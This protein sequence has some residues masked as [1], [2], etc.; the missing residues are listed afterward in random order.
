[1]QSLE[2]DSLALPKPWATQSVAVVLTAQERFAVSSRHV[3]RAVGNTPKSPAIIVFA[4]LVMTGFLTNMLWIACSVHA[5][6]LRA[7]ERRVFIDPTKWGDDH[8]GKPLPEYATGDECLFCHRSDVGNH[9]GKNVHNLSVRRIDAKSKPIVDIANNSRLKNHA[10]QTEFV[11]GG[12][13]HWRFLRSGANYGTLEILSAGWRKGASDGRDTIVDPD[14]PRWERAKFADSCAGCHATAV[15]AKTRAFSAIS[16]ECFSCHGDVP[17]QHAKDIGLAHLSRKRQDK[18]AVITSICAQCHIRTGKSR[19]SG[20]PYPNQFV[21]G[22]NLF[23]DF[24]FDFARSVRTNPIDD[25]VVDNVKAVVIEGRKD[26][27]C[28][29]CHDVHKQNAKRHHR[30]E[31]TD[32]CLHCHDAGKSKKERKKYEVH[33]ELCG[34]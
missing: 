12:K 33:S 18:P 2:R 1:M 3:P 9:W 16:I 21:A 25:H 14:A 6:Q 10:A 29:S 31:E 17:L 15:D 8:V 23:R 22:D 11:L 30:I 13:N 27:T 24:Q 32:F 7:V 20:R 28:L 4:G 34:Y 5:G 26:T 19:S